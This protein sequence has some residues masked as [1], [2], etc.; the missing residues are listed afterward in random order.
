MRA[1]STKAVT[2]K[3]IASSVGVSAMT[4]SNILQDNPSTKYRPKTVERVRYTAERLGYQAN[5]SAQAIRKG[6]T[7]IIGFVAQSATSNQKIWDIVMLPFMTG[8]SQ[9]LIA[10]SKH[11]S[12]VEI[13]DLAG[14][15][16]KALPPIL[17]EKFFDGL[18]VGSRLSN[19]FIKAISESGVPTIFFDCGVFR[20]HNCIY[21]DERYAVRTALNRLMAAG[22]RR[23]AFRWSKGLWGTFERE[24]R[25]YYCFN[26]REKTYQQHMYKHGLSPVSLRSGTMESLI[27]EIRASGCTAILMDSHCPYLTGALF[28]LNYSIPADISVASV[29]CETNLPSIDQSFSGMGF[30]RMAAS[31]LAAEM[32]CQL[33]ESPDKLLPSLAIKPQ[34]KELGTIG[35]PS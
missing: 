6:K 34:W 8:L 31:S 14:T 7:G 9:F 26:A 21:R 20:R 22:H 30:D 4:V 32:I 19:R 27:G 25:M 29:T 28:A 24:K 3:D 2:L 1:I 18:V 35:P 23:I 16:S 12:L 10:R 33:V 11:V 13:Q 15:E 17:Q 5:R